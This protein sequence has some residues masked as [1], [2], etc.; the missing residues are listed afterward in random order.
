MAMNRLL[1]I[2]GAGASFDVISGVPVVIDSRPLLTH[3]LFTPPITAGMT[4]F[5]SKCLAMHPLA[6]QV[7]TD[8]NSRF[9]KDIKAIQLEDYLSELKNSANIILK[10]G[11]WAIPIY[12]FELFYEIS[13]SYLPAGPGFPSNY[14]SLIT[15]LCGSKYKEIIWLNLNYDLLA[16]FAIIKAAKNNLDNFE[17]YLGLSIGRDLTIQ[18]T[19]PHGSI[20]W[21]KIMPRNLDYDN[22]KQ[23]GVPDNFERIITGEIVKGKVHISKLRGR[24]EKENYWYPALTAPVANEKEFV[25]QEHINLVTPILRETTSLLCIG[26]SA[27]DEDILKLIKKNIL[28]VESL[29]IVNSNVTSGNEAYDNLERYGIKMK[30]SKEMAVFDGGF[31]HFIYTGIDKWLTS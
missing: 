28:I 2:T 25:Y 5:S 19:K 18:Y 23:N 22:I 4:H 29:K 3:E 27:M 9:S 7:A 14:Y 24:I 17:E 6:Y 12:F 16:D 1:L 20:D 30:E 21:F 11:F 15:K 8:F 13:Y 26:F 31:S 10:R